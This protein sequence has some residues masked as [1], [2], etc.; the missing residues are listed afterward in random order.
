MII[1]DVSFYLTGI[2]RFRNLFPSVLYRMM[3]QGGL[4]LTPN[5]NAFPSWDMI[6]LFLYINNNVLQ[7]IS[8]AIMAENYNDKSYLVKKL[9]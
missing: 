6:Q 7:V 3:I 5:F 8:L 2:Q 1:N 4:N 9:S